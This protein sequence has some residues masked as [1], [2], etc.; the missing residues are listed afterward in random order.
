MMK[1]TFIDVFILFNAFIFMDLV[2]YVT[3]TYLIII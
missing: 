1:V 2:N 3:N